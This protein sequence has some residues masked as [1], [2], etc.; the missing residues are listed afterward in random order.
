MKG[1]LFVHVAYLRSIQFST[2][3]GLLMSRV[4]ENKGEQKKILAAVVWFMSIF[5][6]D[7]TF[8]ASSLDKQF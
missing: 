8:L 6:L 1:N 4:S 7:G 3:C 5:W 2:F